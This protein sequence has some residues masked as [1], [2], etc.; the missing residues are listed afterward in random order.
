[1]HTRCKAKQLK[2]TVRTRLSSYNIFIPNPNKAGRDVWINGLSGEV[3]RTSPR[4]SSIIKSLSG[5]DGVDTIKELPDAL[6]HRLSRSGI[7]TE[8][9]RGGEEEYF[10]KVVRNIHKN[11]LYASTT[12][13]FVPTYECNLNCSYC[14]QEKTRAKKRIDWRFDEDMIGTIFDFLQ[15]FEQNCLGTKVQQRNFVLYGGEP[16][17][18]KNKPVVSLIADNAVRL[19]AADINAITNAYELE[20]YADLLKDKK[21][22]SLQ[23]TLDG[24]PVAHDKSRALHDGSGTFAKISSNIKMALDS[25]VRVSIRTNIDKNNIGQLPLLAE[26]VIERGW[27]KYENFSIYAGL[28]HGGSSSVKHSDLLNNA[29]LFEAICELMEDNHHMHIYKQSE[30]ELVDVLKE[31]L[32]DDGNLSSLFQPC[33]CGAHHNVI[34]FD[35]QGNIYTC[36]EQDQGGDYRIGGIDPSGKFTIDGGNFDMWKTRTVISN[37]TCRKCPYA[38]FC[39]GGCAIRAKEAKGTMYTNHCSGFQR[40]FKS[41]VEMAM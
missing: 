23:I 32:G 38:L 4:E 30:F 12:Y 34:I 31:N 16:L 25:D 13:V 39:G 1:M 40:L 7:L 41:C 36:M 3:T 29:E 19:Q 35:G 17:L 26:T 28:I 18:A 37:N 8:M 33:F 27:D 15:D 2:V 22:R 20:A 6:F 21:I 9:P 14:F 11:R 24:P 5:P 10:T